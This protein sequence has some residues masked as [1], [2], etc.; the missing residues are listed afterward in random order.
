MNHI[1]FE[2]DTHRA[3]RTDVDSVYEDVDRFV[4]RKTPNMRKLYITSETVG[5]RAAQVETFL[6]SF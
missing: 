4:E 6:R 5:D 2:D 3:S 1:T